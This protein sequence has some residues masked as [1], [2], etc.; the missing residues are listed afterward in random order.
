MTK[1]AANQDWTHYAKTRLHAAGYRGG[2]ARSAVLGLLADQHCCLSAQQIH[3]MLAD[4]GSRVGLASI[5]RALELLSTLRLVHRVDVGGVACFEPAFPS[6]PHHHHAVCECC[7]RLEPFVD[8]TLE[9][10]LES[11]IARLQ[12][13]DALRDVVLRG[14]CHDCVQT[15]R[16]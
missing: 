9:H 7:G 3:E 15:Q 5:Y 6:D 8:A 1:T 11:V 14:Y 13:R 10:A 2:G 16:L 12:Y 4:S